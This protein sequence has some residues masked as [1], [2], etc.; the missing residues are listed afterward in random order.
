[1]SESTI[2]NKSFDFA[3]RIVKLYKFL[4]DEHKEYIISRQLLK[5]GTSIGANVNEAI[6]AQSKKDFISK[7][8]IANKEARET[9][10]WINLLVA[11]EYL[12]S[13]DKHVRSMQQNVEEI[14][15]ILTS[16]IKTSQERL[17]RV[18]STQN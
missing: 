2:Y 15:K 6:S 9:N 3:V 4:I 14:I 13:E 1:M 17:R 12:N 5:S 11:T 7:M 10:Y 18:K 8:A 16:I